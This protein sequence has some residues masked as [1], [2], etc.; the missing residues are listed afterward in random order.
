MMGVLRTLYIVIAV[1]GALLVAVSQSR[2]SPIV[3]SEY[4]MYYIQYTQVEQLEITIISILRKGTNRLLD[5]SA[6]SMQR[7][8]CLDIQCIVVRGRR[9]VPKG[10]SR[11]QNKGIL[12]SRNWTIWQKKRPLT[13][14]QTDEGWHSPKRPYST[15]AP[16]VRQFVQR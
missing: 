13:C 14:V 6:F 1:T 5:H 11:R 12:S 10:R 7:C 16:T 8:K 3:L 15:V 4:Y 9:L 2:Q